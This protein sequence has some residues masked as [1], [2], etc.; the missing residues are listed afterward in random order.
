MLNAVRRGP[1]S[2]TRLL[3]LPFVPSICAK[4]APSLRLSHNPP[5]TLASTTSRPFSCFPR[6]NQ[7]YA[8]Q[9]R[10]EYEEIEDEVED[11]VNS[12]R[13]PSNSEIDAGAGG[14]LVTKFADLLKR[15][16]VSYE[17]VRTLT[18][19]MGLVTMTQ[20]QSMTINETLKGVDT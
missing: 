2:L 13:P 9:A 1:A 10:R 20:V 3:S 6:L 18:E 8:Q 14:G 4:A 7:A 5:R 19:D 17:I 11:E 15:K 12:Q 16:M